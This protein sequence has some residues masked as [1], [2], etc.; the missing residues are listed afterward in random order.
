MNEKLLEKKLREGVKKM[1]GLALKFSSQT[2]TGIPDRIILMPGGF[3][4]FVE[5]KT[6]GKKPSPRQ[7]A[8]IS[9]LRIMG[10]KADVIDSQ[11]S[12]DRLLKFLTRFQ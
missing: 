12:L 10:F 3:T 7:E 5:L 9:Q 8:T 4:C 2:Y 11:E 1:G 6:T